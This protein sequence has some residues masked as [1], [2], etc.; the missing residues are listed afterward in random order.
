MR[1]SATCQE[2]YYPEH[3]YSE[4]LIEEKLIVVCFRQAVCHPLDVRMGPKDCFLDSNFL[5]LIF[6]DDYVQAWIV[7]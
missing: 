4:L 5:E 1:V 6:V 7:L 3:V 2:L